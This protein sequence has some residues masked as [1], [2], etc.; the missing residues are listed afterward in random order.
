MKETYY[1]SHDYNSRSDEKIK[2][3][4]RKHGMLG[5]GIFWSIVENLYNNANALR[6]DYEGIAYDLRVDEV[7][8]K[9]IINDFDLFVIEN[10]SFGSISVER[11]INEKNAKSKTARKSAISRWE[12]HRHNAD[13]L[14]P[15]ASALQEEIERNALKEEK[16]RK[17]KEIKDKLDAAIAAAIKRKS[18]FYNSLVPYLKKYSTE[19]IRSFYDY[20]TELNK[21]GVKMRFELEK[22]W[23]IPKRLGT[24]AKNEKFSGEKI[25]PIAKIN[26]QWKSTV[27]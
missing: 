4:I 17:E 27:N 19:M 22:T 8:A 9:S 10:D 6:T 12:K 26:E 11:R 21:S 1:F 18:D 16:E 25:K 14:N 23:E 15:D 2:L 5:Y 7:I 24:W 20:W 3:L 13:A